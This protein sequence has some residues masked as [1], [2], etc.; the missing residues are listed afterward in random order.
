MA[1]LLDLTDIPCSSDSVSLFTFIFVWLFLAVSAPRFILPVSSVSLSFVFS[2]SLVS[3]ASGCF[4]CRFLSLSLLVSL[5]LSLYHFLFFCL[6]LLL[7]IPEPVSAS[8]SPSFCPHL[9]A[10]STQPALTL[11]FPKLL[12]QILRLLLDSFLNTLLPHP[13]VLHGGHRESP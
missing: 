13:E 11:G 9:I 10:T 7:S 5:C 1:S 6:C 12:H 8:L 2:L 4:L 3:C